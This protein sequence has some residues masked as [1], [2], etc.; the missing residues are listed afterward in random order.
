MVETQHCI[1]TNNIDATQYK[2]TNSGDAA[3]NRHIVEMRHSIGTQI[4]E[5]QH[6]IDINNVDAT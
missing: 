6:C 2:E 5:T 3:L 4:V 1:D